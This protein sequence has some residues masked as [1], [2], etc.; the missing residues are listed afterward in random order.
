METS[1]NKIVQIDITKLHPHDKNPRKNVGDISEL[2]ESIKKNGIL[3]N[4][5]V[6]PSTGYYYGDY[7]V[8]IGHRRLAAA[9]E[10]GLTELPCIISNM[11]PEEQFHTMLTEN[12][13]RVDLTPMEQAQGFQIMFDEWGYDEK[14]I[15]ETTGFSESTVRHRLNMAKLNINA[16]EK[17]EK[18]NGF[19]L[20]LSDFY[21]LE[22]VPTIKGRNEIL[23]NA[24]SSRDIQNRAARAETEARRNKAEKNIIKLLKK[25]RPDIEPFP[26]NS[27]TWDG[28]WEELKSISLDGVVPDKIAIGKAKKEDKLYYS[29]SYISLDIYRKKPKQKKVE[30][31][32][33]RKE[34]ELNKR[35][36][37]LGAVL[38]KMAARR[39]DFVLAVIDGKIDALPAKETEAIKDE[40][41]KILISDDVYTYIS[42][43][44]IVDFIIGKNSYDAS[45]EER[46]EAEAKAETLN[47]LHQMLAT[48][49][50]VLKDV[51]TYEW[52]GTVN[53][54][55][56]DIL[57][58]G[59]AVL[60]RYGWTFEDGEEAVLDGTHELYTKEE[61]NEYSS[62]KNT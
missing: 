46:E 39:R 48:M 53:K 40:I 54:N 38:K 6:V 41:W 12:M 56:A 27:Y 24:S 4:L 7:T 29:R 9:K 30:T 3:Q 25:T 45:K 20:S 16:V 28:T 51:S 43:Q 52:N 2:A 44:G 26:K 36:K 32:A 21:A 15:S 37:Q 1:E 11:T 22:K 17:Y 49:C 18:N 10:A 13:Q 42:N 14:K 19:Q 8:I 62:E 47:I 59:Y 61:T 31:D 50:K 57:K 23:K 5:T 60:E 58:S 34:K 55:K 35:R 33:D